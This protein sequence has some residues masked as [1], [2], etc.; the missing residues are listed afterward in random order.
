MQIALGELQK[1]A[2]PDQRVTAPA[3]TVFPTKDFNEL[4]DADAD[5]LASGESREDQLWAIYRDESEAGS[6]RSYLSAVETYL[7][8]SERADFDA[9]VKGW[10]NDNDFHPHWTAVFDSSLRVDRAD[11]PSSAPDDL[12]RES[13][14]ASPATTYGEFKRDQLPVWLVSGN[15]GLGFDPVSD[16]SYPA[17]YQTPRT[18]LPD[19]TDDDAIV[20]LVGEGSA[21][22]ENLSA[23]GLDGRVKARKVNIPGAS[24]QARGG[25][26][27]WVGDESVKAN[28]SIHSEDPDTVSSSAYLN[29]LQAPQRTGWERMEGFAS[30]S[31]TPFDENFERILTLPQIPLVEPADLADDPLARGPVPRNFHSLTTHSQSLLT[32]TARGGLRKD[33]TQFLRRGAGLSPSDPVANPDH[34]RS[35]DSRFGAWGGSNAG[36]PASTNNIPTW[37][38]IRSWFNNTAASAGGTVTPD[39]NTHPLLTYVMFHGG[40]SYEPSTGLVRM[41][42]LP[43]IMLWNPYD[44]SLAGAQ[45]EVELGISPVLWKFFVGVPVEE[46]PTDAA[47]HYDADNDF[48]Y[49]R[50]DD[51]PGRSSLGGNSAES[52]YRAWPMES[53]STMPPGPEDRDIAYPLRF[54]IGASETSFEPGEVLVFTLGATTAWVPESGNPLPLINLYDT[55]LPDSLHFPVARIETP[56]SPAQQSELRYFFLQT[57]QTIAAPRV[58]VKMNGNPIIRAGARNELGPIRYNDMLEAIHGENYNQAVDNSSLK[59]WEIDPP[60]RPDTWRRLHSTGDFEAH[61]NTTQPSATASSIWPYGETWLQPLN[62]ASTSSFTDNMGMPQRAHQLYPAFGSF[63]FNAGFIGLHPRVDAERTLN[64]NVTDRPN[65]NN[66]D[67]LGRMQ[68]YRTR[69]AN[70]A[71]VWNGFQSSGPNGFSIISPRNESGAD[72]YQGLSRLAVRPARRTEATLLSLGQIQQANLSPFIWQPAFP[73]GNAQASPYVDRAAIAGIHSRPMGGAISGSGELG[74][75]GND[76]QNRLIDL[77]YLLNETLWNGFFLSG[78]EGTV[79]GT[80]R[81]PNSRLRFTEDAVD[82]PSGELLRDFDTAAAY[83]RNHG[84]L[85]VNSTSVEAW[86]ALLTAFR[87]LNLSPQDGSSNPD[88]TIPVVRSLIPV[89]E[90]IDYQLQGSGG[91]VTGGTADP[92]DFGAVSNQRDLSRVM[93]GFRYLNDDMVRILAERIVDE[94]RLRGPFYS[95]SDFVNRRLVPPH[96]AGQSGSAWQRA[97]TSNGGSKSNLEYIAPSY[98]PF[99]GLHGLTGALQRVI[100][101]SGINGG[102]NNIQASPEDRVYT[103]RFKDRGGQ[104]PGNQA[105]SDIYSD[106]NPRSNYEP[107]THHHLD[108]EHMA[109]AA[110]GEAGNLYNGTP[111][112]LTQGDLL[113]MIGPALTARGDTFVIRSYGES[114]GGVTGDVAARAWLETVVQRVAEP[115][116]PAGTSGANAW[117]PDDPFGRK[118]RIVSMHWLQ[119]DEI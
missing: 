77:S 76:N 46:E 44:A 1:H 24:A 47:G 49:F 51:P 59:P 60:F 32:D 56:P 90:K 109:G 23:D 61:Y 45:Y 10:W 35:S 12:T 114:A 58:T 78:I 21:T 101:T 100:D 18:P 3:T 50:L 38:E 41:H 54:T 63:N 80:E 108:A 112:L 116:T 5:I 11:N 37:G 31:L 81:L 53:T 91:G 28:V 97:R 98:D 9:K 89:E 22:R 2:G 87:D 6:A 117:R 88:D 119:K 111:G 93:G 34:Y 36:F 8:H 102:L 29:F 19:P 73:I 75:L 94:V 115:M 110:A 92:Q 64:L 82:A 65:N 107:T 14:E 84:A 85:N 71:P 70:P 4:Y 52:G 62:T 113:S 16:T 79:S 72:E 69:F 105:P 57:Q 99:V 106:D 67:N 27:Y 104:T 39:G 66:T 40:M 68:F 20:W 43:A 118:F 26:A 33:L 30:V 96:G 83:L 55:A 95:L 74:T 103:L 42:F 13:Y 7:T 48:F 86:V 25:Y 17:D 15:E